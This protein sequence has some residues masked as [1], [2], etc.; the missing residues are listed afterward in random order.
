MSNRIAPDGGYTFG[1]KRQYRRDV[2]AAFKRVC[3]VPRAEAQCLLMPSSEGKEIDVALACGFREEHLHVVDRNPAIVAHLKRR[4]P[5]LQT[6]GT[7]LKAA[8]WRIADKGIRLH[9]A[10]LDLCGCVGPTH[11]EEICYFCQ[12]GALANGAS[13]AVTAL[14]GREQNANDLRDRG[15]RA[16][17]VVLSGEGMPPWMTDMD[18]GRV[19]EIVSAIRMAFG[20]RAW[21]RQA[22]RYMSASG[23]TMLWVVATRHHFVCRCESCVS[24]QGNRLPGAVSIRDPKTFAPGSWRRM[25]PAFTTDQAS[26]DEIAQ[27]LTSI[28][29]VCGW[30]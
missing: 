27:Q 8:G 11:F 17:Q 29:D 21:I 10:N 5:K 1:Q 16:L 3:W 18:R 28:H 6:Y 13:V 14:R 7:D 2:W 20:A 4:Y 24:W 25:P 9:L 30:G 19:S 15:S 22:G 26:H 12:S 23:Q